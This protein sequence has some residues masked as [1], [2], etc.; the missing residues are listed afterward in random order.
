[1][2][3]E[4][5]SIVII[6]F[7]CCDIGLALSFSKSGAHAFSKNHF[8]SPINKEDETIISSQLK[9]A[10]LVGVEDY[11]E[12]STLNGPVKD[13][14]ALREALISVAGFQPDNIFI[15]ARP[16]SCKNVDSLSPTSRQFTQKLRQ[17]ISKVPKGSFLLI[18]FSG[19]GL[20]KDNESYLMLQDSSLDEERQPV[21]AFKVKEIKG[22]IESEQF[23]AEHVLV[24]LDACRN[25]IGEDEQNRNAPLEDKFID[26]FQFDNL[27]KRTRSITVLFSAGVGEKSYI[28]SYEPIS[29]FTWAVIKGLLGEAANVNGKVNI[30][31]LTEYVKGEVPKLARYDFLGSYNNRQNPSSR[32]YG[33]NAKDVVIAELPLPS[34]HFTYT[35]EVVLRPTTSLGQFLSHQ[36]VDYI[37]QRLSTS[38]DDM[39]PLNVVEAKPALAPIKVKY[40]NGDIARVSEMDYLVRMTIHFGKWHHAFILCPE[41]PQLQE[42]GAFEPQI[43]T[44][45]SEDKQVLTIDATNLFSRWG[46]MLGDMI[47]EAQENPPK[48]E[49]KTFTKCPEFIPNPK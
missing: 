33:K 42:R 49:S 31:D 4:F 26:S 41:S 20:V 8:Y 32:F 21:N 14:C 35:V 3:K 30:E 13:I 47:I 2:V 43:K 11:D 22:I 5:L 27:N 15:L 12:I 9:Y 29:Y 48:A 38:I 40:S 28:R 17:F 34:Y 6:I 18:A 36:H 46:H 7:C 10:F 39:F 23:Q 45:L 25:T 37:S 16:S 1:M 19:H 24:L 44:F